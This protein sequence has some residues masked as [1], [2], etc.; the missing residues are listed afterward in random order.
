MFLAYYGLRWG[1]VLCK[2][3]RNFPPMAAG[4][5]PFPLTT[6]LLVFSAV[7]IFSANFYFLFSCMV[8]GAWGSV[9]FFLFCDWVSIV[10][11]L[12]PV[13]SPIR[14]GEIL[15]CYLS[16]LISASSIGCIFTLAFISQYST[17]HLVSSPFSIFLYSFFFA[18][19][20]C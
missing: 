9:P 18:F 17:V 5:S 14:S 7:L 15:L 1:G 3:I 8:L 10:F 20:F 4:S 12:L 13:V 6:Y 19:E 2:M 11:F 16:F